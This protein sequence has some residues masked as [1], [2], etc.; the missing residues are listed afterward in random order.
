MIK[1]EEINTENVPGKSLK[2]VYYFSSYCDELHATFNRGKLLWRSRLTWQLS[3]LK[4]NYSQ[5]NHTY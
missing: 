3:Q 4:Y 5:L 1:Y 2:S